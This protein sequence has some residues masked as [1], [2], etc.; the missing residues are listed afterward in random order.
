MRYINAGPE[1]PIS[2]ELCGVTL[3]CDGMVDTTTGQSVYTDFGSES[4]GL[5]LQDA[6]DL[7]INGGK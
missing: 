5:T 3:Y 4:I 7:T 2:V 6:R 1:W